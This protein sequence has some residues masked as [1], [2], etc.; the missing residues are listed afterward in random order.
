MDESGDEVDWDF[1]GG[2]GD[3]QGMDDSNGKERSLSRD[4][5]RPRNE[6]TTMEDGGTLD[7]LSKDAPRDHSGH[8][9]PMVE[10]KIQ[11][12]A[13]EI[14]DWACNKALDECADKVMGEDDTEQVD[15]V[16][17]MEEE[18][19]AGN[20]V[21]QQLESPAVVGAA[22]QSIA[23]AVQCREFVYPPAASAGVSPGA[24]GPAALLS[25]GLGEATVLHGGLGVAA[26]VSAP[27]DDPEQMVV[28]PIV[29]TAAH[30]GPVSAQERP[31]DPLLVAGPEGG[32]VV[33]TAGGLTAPSPDGVVDLFQPMTSEAIWGAAAVKEIQGSATR[34]SP[35]LANVAGDRVLDHAKK[36][37]A[38]KNLEGNEGNSFLS[39]KDSCLLSSFSNLGV[40]LDNN[41][42]DP[43]VSLTNF[44]RLE[45]ESLS[46]A[47]SSDEHGASV[48][49]GKDDEEVN[50]DFENLTLGH[51]GGDLMEEVMDEDD[52]HLSS[53][54]KTVFKKNKSRGK[55]K[56]AKLK[57]VRKYKKCPK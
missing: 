52:D 45:H 49:S 41:G 54:F 11:A 22:L 33:G 47:C 40:L 56:S 39:F 7:N 8:L 20:L 53:D 55:N 29:E 38:W 23:A 14:L 27:L 35:L 5:K 43:S 6:D 18:C 2:N 19:F 25:G 42:I 28:L 24:L 44:S 32:A 13:K 30:V 48:D 17:S 9:D 10:E 34:A 21:E 31:G 46:L 36:R 50:F 26:E 4:P 15:G 3:D 37:T 12:M 51:L 16:C 57:V 1:L